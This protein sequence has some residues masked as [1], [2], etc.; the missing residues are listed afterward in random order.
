MRKRAYLWIC[1]F[2]NRKQVH[3]V[4]LFKSG[5]FHAIKVIFT[6]KNLDP[7]EEN[8]IVRTFGIGKYFQLDSLSALA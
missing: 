4:L 5:M 2:D 1:M 7:F 6:K 8:D 3:D